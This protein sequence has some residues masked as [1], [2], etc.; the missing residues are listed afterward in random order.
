MRVASFKKEVYFFFS[1]QVLDSPDRLL[2]VP[3]EYFYKFN[4]S[5]G[6]ERSIKVHHYVVYILRIPN[7][8]KEVG[9]KSS[10]VRASTSQINV[11]INCS[12][13][14]P[15]WWGFRTFHA[16]QKRPFIDLTHLQL[17]FLK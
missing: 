13:P 1:I 2:T 16:S 5:N 4:I 12:V 14:R 10:C 6:T 17:H 3:G 7:L 11:G 8:R 15:F 9:D